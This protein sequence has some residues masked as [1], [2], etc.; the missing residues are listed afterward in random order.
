MMPDFH[1]TCTFVAHYQD[2]QRRKAD[3]F[4]LALIAGQD[5]ARLRFYYPL[6]ERLGGW[7]IERGN[8]MQA[9]YGELKE[10]ANASVEPKRQA[11]HLHIR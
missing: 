1:N 5:Q 9:R 3:Q 2:D 8:R 7:L 11:A 4:R 10:A 6:L